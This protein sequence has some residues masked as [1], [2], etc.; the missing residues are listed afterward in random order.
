MKPQDF[1]IKIPANL[2]KEDFVAGF[3][4]GIKSN[5]LT[6]FKLSYRMGFR[7]AKLL[8]IELR[9]QQGVLQF[10]MKAK[11]KLKAIDKNEI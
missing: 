1:G 11:F 5:T 7:T 6:K 4:H 10:P 9:K 2:V 8:L 3:E